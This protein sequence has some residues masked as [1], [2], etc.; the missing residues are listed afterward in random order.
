MNPIFFYF[1]YWWSYSCC[2]S[3]HKFNFLCLQIGRKK[4][5]LNLGNYQQVKWY[6]FEYV[7]VSNI[8]YFKSRFVDN[9]ILSHYETIE[10][11]VFCNNRNNVVFFPNEN[12][13]KKKWKYREIIPL[14]LGDTD[15]LET[16]YYF[17]F[18]FLHCC[19]VFIISSCSLCCCWCRWESRER[20]PIIERQNQIE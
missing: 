20:H 11:V 17:F 15:R 16:F 12:G 18:L 8:Y 6:Q 13:E 10:C 19:F 5:C 2:F 1:W 3:L 9:T 7:G 14:F 4:L